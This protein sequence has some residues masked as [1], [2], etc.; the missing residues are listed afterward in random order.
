MQTLGDDVNEL[1]FNQF[2]VVL[3]EEK[4]TNPS[5]YSTLLKRGNV[6]EALSFFKS[7]EE[8]GEYFTDEIQDA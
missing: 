5:R 7:L 6:S 3:N 2:C 8:E 1:T 4:S